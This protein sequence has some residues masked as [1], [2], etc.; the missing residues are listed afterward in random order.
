MK[1][2]VVLGTRPEILKNYSVVKA[3]RS[4]KV[5][6]YILYTNQHSDYRMCGSFFEAM[7]YESDF[8]LGGE[9]ELGRAIDWVRGLIERLGIDLII[10]NGDTAAALVGGIA[11]LYS[12]AGL[13]HIEAGLRAHDREMYE[14]RNRIIVDSLA[15]YLFTYTEEE[16]EYLETIPDLRG[17]VFCTGN[18]TV[19]LITDFNNRIEAVDEDNY[20][21]VT[22][23]RKEFTDSK[24]RMTTVLGTIN[25]LADRFDHI[26]FPVHPRTRDMIERHAIPFSVM[27]RITIFDPIP[28]F[29]SLSYE[30]HARIILTDSG[31]LQEEA[32]IFGVPCITVRESTERHGTVR[33][34]AN[35]VCGFDRDGILEAVNVQMQRCGDSYPPLYGKY[36]AGAR[37]VDIILG[38]FKNFR[39]Y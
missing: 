39:E 5:E 20:M 11:A 15:H 31:C 21:Y 17:R 2:G 24:E 19:D 35:V 30:K 1:I 38:N 27:D 37:I 32:Y 23:H 6:F 28:V 14:E 22:L 12:D 33:A 8:V 26:I 16:K 25:S 34:G 9:Y 18:T 36:G 29:E 4:Q 3:M 10:V 7:E 13:A